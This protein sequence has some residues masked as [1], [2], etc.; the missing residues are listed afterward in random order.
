M[1]D[2]DLMMPG[3]GLTAIGLSGVILSYLGIANTFL[4]GMQA[5][6]GLTMIMGMVFLSAGILNGGVSTSGRA[7]A[8][9]LVI[10][11]IAGS[12]GVYALSLNTV[13]TSMPRFIGVLII[14]IIPTIV[15][16]F[17]SMKMQ[18]YFKPVAVIFVAAMA[19]GV[20]SYTA[21]GFL[22]PGAQFSLHT[23]NE[24]NATAANATLPTA[25]VIM[26]NIPV[27]SSIKGNPNFTPNTVT[28]PKGDIIKWTNNDTVPHTVTSAADAGA[29][30]DSSLIAAGKSYSLDT[31][32]LNATEYD[33]MCTVHPF[34][35]GKIMITQ[36]IIANVTISKGAST[37]SAGQKYFD[38]A[39]LSVKVGTTVIWTNQDSSAHTVTSGDPTAGPS[40]QFDSGLI[41]PG[42]T[43]KH[44]FTAAGTTSYFCTV[45][46]WMTGKIIVG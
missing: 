20:G 46:P 43:F 26:V 21:F 18:K 36:P 3:M 37:Q 32:K 1:S 34:M 6:S 10:F 33:Y 5:L 9:T 44:T 38:P 28:V 11:G 42:N 22:G 30:F 4:T 39:S 24:T 23:Q 8:T 25:P 41:K 27:N 13:I 40:G 15:I 7:K 2:W 19:V 29:T 45:H 16:G 35:T 12:V 17:T 31:S 14:I